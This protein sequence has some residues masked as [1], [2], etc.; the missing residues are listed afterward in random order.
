MINQ[1]LRYK[2]IVDYLKVHAGYNV[3]EVGVGSQGIGL[4]LRER[5]LRQ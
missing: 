1:K 5:H 2:P 4:T 3:L